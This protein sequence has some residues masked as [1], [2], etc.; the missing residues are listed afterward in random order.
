MNDDS[1]LKYKFSGDLINRNA[2][3]HYHRKGDTLLL[4]YRWNK[5]NLEDMFAEVS[6]GDIQLQLNEDT[7]HR[8]RYIIGHNKL[9]PIHFKTGKKVTRDVR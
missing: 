4:Y 5:D 8:E 2:T 6:N 7:V 1:T 9:Y 3:G